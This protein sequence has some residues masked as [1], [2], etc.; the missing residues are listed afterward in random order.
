MTMEEFVESYGEK[1]LKKQ[2]HR[3]Y[4]D[5]NSVNSFTQD[6]QRKKTNV[7]NHQKNKNSNGGVLSEDLLKQFDKTNSEVPSHF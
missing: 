4:E 2:M 3:E 1:E 6:P 5:L 7:G